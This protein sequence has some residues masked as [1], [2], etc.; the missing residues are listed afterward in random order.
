MTIFRDRI[1]ELRGYSSQTEFAKKFEVSPVTISAIEAGKQNPSWDLA[2]KVCEEYKCSMDWLC[3]RTELRNLPN[4]SN[5]KKN[6]EELEK[7][8]FIIESYKRFVKLII[9]T[10]FCNA[11]Y[12][13]YNDIKIYDH[14]NTEELA[15][16]YKEGLWR[17][18]FIFLALEQNMVDDKNLLKIHQNFLQHMKYEIAINDNKEYL[19]Q[20]LHVSIYNS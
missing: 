3:G 14:I 11:Y 9:H 1:K 6:N 18:I 15:I 16:L 10:H 17:E 8:N 2:L 13:K 4:D 19:N 5:D 12:K 7:G 20:L